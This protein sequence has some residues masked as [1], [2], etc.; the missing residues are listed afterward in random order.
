MV[1]YKCSYSRYFFPEIFL[2][3]PPLVLV[4]WYPKNT[5]HAN[6]PIIECVFGEKII[7]EART[8]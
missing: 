2:S 8:R 6:Y 3:T 1:Y 4:L 7:P 5:I